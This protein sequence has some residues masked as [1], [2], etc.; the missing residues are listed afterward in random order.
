MEGP[1]SA[2]G[3]RGHRLFMCQPATIEPN[4]QAKWRFA[5]NGKFSAFVRGVALRAFQQ[6]SA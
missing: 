1:R 6:W 4:S 5:A 2:V 3:H